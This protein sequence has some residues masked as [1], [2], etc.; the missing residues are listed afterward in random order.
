MCPN[1]NLLI[2]KTGAVKWDN[3][4][5][6]QGRSFFYEIES[7]G[8]ELFTY[9]PYDQEVSYPKDIPPIKRL[10]VGYK[11]DSDLTIWREE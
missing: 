9:D 7:I 5:R 2:Y 11:I 6:S 10:F 3:K 1:K 4:I 8:L